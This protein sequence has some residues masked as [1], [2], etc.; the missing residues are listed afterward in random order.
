MN[1]ASEIDPS[2]IFNCLDYKA[3][4]ARVIRNKTGRPLF[5]Q[6]IAVKF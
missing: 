1:L 5:Y 2:K 6:Q 4:H 3:G